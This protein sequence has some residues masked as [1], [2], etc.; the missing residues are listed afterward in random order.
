VL[1]RILQGG[2]NMDSRNLINGEWVIPEGTTKDVWNPANM[3][4][5]VGTLHCSG[6]DHV[7]Y[8]VDAARL[9]LKDWSRRTGAE[10][11]DFLYK[12]SS[13]METHREELAKLAS[14]EMGKPLHEMLGEVTRGINILRYYAGEGMREIG[15]VIPA[16]QKNVLQYSKRVPLG[17]VGV[18]TP[19]NFP[20]AIPIWKIAP[21]LICGNTIVWKPAENASLTATRLV[22]LFVEAELPAGVINLVIGK[23]SVIGNTLLEEE[24]VKAVSFTG[25][26][27][28]GQWIASACVKRNIKFQTEMGG[29]NVAVIL[30]DADLSKTIPAIVSGAYSS[31]GQKCT[32]TSR[33][34]VED[35]IYEDVKRELSQ[36]VSNLK[37]GDPF[38]SAN[39]L[40]PV[41]SREQF[42]TVSKYIEM[43]R[44]GA[45]VAEGTITANPDQGYFIAPLLAEGFGIDHPLIQEEIFGPVA[46]LL[47][48][49]SFE[50]AVEACNNTIFGLTA[51]VFTSNLQNGLRFLDEAEAG[52]VRVNLETAGVEYQAPFGGMKMSSSHTRE[53]GAAALQF[54]TQ[55]KTCAISYE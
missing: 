19:W 43:A 49:H 42:E 35:A 32:A 39:Y 16:S 15:N 3:T 29:K 13:L 6:P 24:G 12:I 14:S 52:M 55:V 21:A 28:T 48:V 51:S 30:A 5:K 9:A 27:S 17:V 41:A 46:A 2:L 50:E 25:S 26:T 44:Q 38:D 8:V 45:V 31:A 53:Q 23:G 22:E 20:V 33:I 18:I 4:G 37:T 40:G 47:R 11:A 54:Y 7:K 36:A 10:R 1:K 34:I